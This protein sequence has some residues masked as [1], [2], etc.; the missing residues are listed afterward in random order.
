MLI[1]N[2]NCPNCGTRKTETRDTDKIMSNTTISCHTCGG[3]M[4]LVSVNIIK[5]KYKYLVHDNEKKYGV[6]DDYGAA[7]CLANFIDACVQ[8]IEIIPKTEK[9]KG[10]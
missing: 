5:S 1:L 8:E 10:E 3:R 4:K 7:A 6:F 2:F 9:D